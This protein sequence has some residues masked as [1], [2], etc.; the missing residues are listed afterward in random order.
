MPKL[1]PTRRATFYLLRSPCGADAARSPWVHLARARHRPL[2]HPRRRGRRRGDGRA[3][4]SLQARRVRAFR[5]RSPASPAASTRCS[6]R[7]VTV[8]ET[9]SIA[10]AVNVVLMSALGGTRHWLGPRSARSRSPRSSTR[11]TAGAGG[12][13]PGG[14]GAIL[15]AGSCS[16]RRASSVSWRCAAEASAGRVSADGRGADAAGRRGRASRASPSRRGVRRRRSHAAASAAARARPAQVVQAACG[17]RRR[18]RRGAPRRDPRPARA[19]RLGQ[20]DVHQRRE[21]ALPRRRRRASCSTGSEL[22]GCRRTASRAPASRAP[23]R[24][25]GRSRTSRCSTTWR[26]RRCSAGER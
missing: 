24:S 8:A 9:F 22:I 19:E 4:L 14:V 1:A 12:R 13:R 21:R 16:C 25:R 10:L 15:I 17:A 23:T 5:A 11:F 6:C 7:Y 20:V 26:C 18:R 3:D 2:R